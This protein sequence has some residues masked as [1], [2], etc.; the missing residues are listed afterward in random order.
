MD[1]KVRIQ[2]VRRI[3]VTV[4]AMTFV[5][6]VVGSWVKATGSGLACPDW[7]QCWGQW[8]PPFPSAENGGLDPDAY[9]PADAWPQANILYE[10]AHRLL[11]SLLGIPFLAF[12]IL[13]AMEPR[14]HKG[15]R[16]LPMGALAI[17]AFQVR[18]GGITVEQGNAAPLTT[19]HLA[20]AT[21]FFFTVSLATAFA[22]LR[23]LAPMEAE[24]GSSTPTA[25]AEADA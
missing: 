11:A 1:V 13:T 3:G 9:D 15:L 22:Y 14:F 12:V 4:V 24:A 16:W 10:W 2:W 8:L 21:L 17:L 6:M 23:P 19:A 18:L 25:T 20:T 5:L 7:P